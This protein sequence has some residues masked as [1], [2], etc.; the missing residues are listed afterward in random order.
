[1]GNDNMKYLTADEMDKYISWLTGI[2]DPDVDFPT[3]IF[4]DRKAEVWFFERP[5]LA[6]QDVMTDFFNKSVQEFG[7]DIIA[8]FSGMSPDLRSAFVLDGGSIEADYADL[9]GKYV[10]FQGG[11]LGYPM[12]ISDQ[13]L[14]WILYE[15]AREEIGI[16]GLTK[17]L[18]NDN[19]KS[20]IDDVFVD[21]DSIMGGEF[22]QFMKIF[23]NGFLSED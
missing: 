4:K 11:I 9:F 5:I 19:F 21:G 18:G 20:I 6:W 2:V 12:I 1:M 16:I 3:N 14:N 23:R 15:S 8:K 7:G 10:N 13:K 17:S 22:S